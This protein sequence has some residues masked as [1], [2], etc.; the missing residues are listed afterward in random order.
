MSTA[1]PPPFGR[2]GRFSLRFSLRT[3]FLMVSLCAVALGWW[4]Q[5]YQESSKVTIRDPLHDSHADYLG[6]NGQR[7]ATEIRTMRRQFLAPPVQDGWTVSYHAPGKKA[8]EESWSCGERHGPRRY[9]DPQGRKRI[10]EHWSCG[11]LHGRQRRWDEH[12]RLVLEIEYAAGAAVRF[13]WT[14]STIDGPTCAAHE[15]LL[16]ATDLDFIEAPL[17]EVIAY[18]AERHRLPVYFDRRVLD[19]AGVNAETNVTIQEQDIPLCLAL[20]L[21]LEPRALTCVQRFDLLWITTRANAKSWRDRTGL[22]TLRPEPGSALADALSRLARS[23]DFLETPLQEVAD[24]LTADFSI[25]I[26]CQGDTLDKPGYRGA[27]PNV[28]LCIDGL[29]LRSILGIVCEQCNF[30]C[31][32]TDDGLVLQP[33]GFEE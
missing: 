33:V 13:H 30:R 20:H 16:A 9:F 3:L 6:E 15:Q 31:E 28:T 5:P 7:N 4:R 23:P 12:G 26:D 17:E 19:A 29:P 22:E 24:A 2:R 25:P 1:S 21:L 11:K 32:Q 8:F 18:L 14:G 27:P 10:E